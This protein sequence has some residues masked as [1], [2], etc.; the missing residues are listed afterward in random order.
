[1]ID[2]KLIR[3]NPELVKKNC[4]NRGYDSKSVDEILAIDRKWRILK[5]QDDD[6]RAE[7]NKISK[8]INEAKKQKKDISQFLKE[9]KEIPEKLERNEN[10]EKELKKNLD[11]L[12]S[13]IPNMQKE[14]VPVGGEEKNKVIHKKG[15]I[16]KFSFSVKS[17]VE[18]LEKLNL[19]NMEEGVKV[20]G[21]GFYMLKG[22]LAQ[23]ERALINFMLDFHIKDGFTEINPP[24]LVNSKTMFGT[25]QLPKFENDLY[26]T[27]EGFYLIPTAEVVVTNLH[28]D[29]VLNEKD[30]PKKYVSIIFSQID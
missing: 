30:L 9:A 24:Q 20:A 7:K 26:K 25:G 3:E 22:E 11:L 13:S 21:S 1:M 29:E 4:K 14:D 15:K 17:H 5:K 8:Q 19:L 27:R 23:F 18:L 16:P 2:T 10:E 12:L 6:L 28:A